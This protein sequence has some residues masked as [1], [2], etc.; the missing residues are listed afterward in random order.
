MHPAVLAAQD[1]AAPPYTM[2]EADRLNDVCQGT[3][4]GDAAACA[5]RDAA[6]RQLATQGHCYRYV[7]RAKVPPR[8][9]TCGAGDLR[10]LP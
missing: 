7:G 2:D 3:P 10:A 1:H 9:H 8:W 4:I 6:Y 5:A